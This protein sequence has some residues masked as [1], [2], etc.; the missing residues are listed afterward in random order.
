[1]ETQNV[2]KKEW[3]QIRKLVSFGVNV[4]DS[5]ATACGLYHSTEH[6]A[7]RELG[8]LCAKLHLRCGA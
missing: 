5:R 7:S 1:M 3:E 4:P 8:Y 6:H 2:S